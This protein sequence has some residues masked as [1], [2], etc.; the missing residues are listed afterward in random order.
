M[1]CAPVFLAAE[2]RIPQINLAQAPDFRVGQAE[3]GRM[4][5]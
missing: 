4:V 3:L 5:S 2:N 1:N